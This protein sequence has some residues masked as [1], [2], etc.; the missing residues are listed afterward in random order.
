MIVF[1]I[2]YCLILIKKFASIQ[3]LN[4]LIALIFINLF[5]S[6]FISFYDFIFYYLLFSFCNFLQFF[7]SIILY[8][9]FFIKNYF[10]FYVQTL[11]ILL[12]LDL[13]IN[14]MFGYL[15]LFFSTTFSKLIPS[16]L[17]NLNDDLIWILSINLYISDK[18]IL[19]HYKWILIIKLI[20]LPLLQN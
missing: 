13:G 14:F 5:I 3:Y 2:I 17:K 10:F 4:Y 12:C 1:R 19:M 16:K 20:I 18:I 15:N 7:I 8:Y 11:K 9:L 6:Q